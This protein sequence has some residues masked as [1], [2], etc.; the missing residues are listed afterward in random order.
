[1]QFKLPDIKAVSFKVSGASTDCEKLMP[2]TSIE[3]IDLG[4]KI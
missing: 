4:L 1:M 2:L 3:G